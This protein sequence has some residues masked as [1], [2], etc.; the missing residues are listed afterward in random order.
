MSK[1]WENASSRDYIKV[2]QL[3]DRFIFQSQVLEF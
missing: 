2:Q 1:T 3:V